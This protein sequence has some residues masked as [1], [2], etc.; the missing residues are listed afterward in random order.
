MKGTIIVLALAGAAFAQTAT[1]K[2]V[3]TDIKNDEGKVGLSIFD[4]AEGFPGGEHA[5]ENVWTEI[6]DGV[7]TYEFEVPYGTYA[8]SAMHDENDD[9]ELETNWV[10]MPTEGIG[11][12]NDAEGNMG[13]PSFEDASFRVNKKTVTVAFTMRY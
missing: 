7:A 13:P 9:N 3:V 6:K 5:I 10:G 4:D 11:V 2:A 12:S 8:I 1:V